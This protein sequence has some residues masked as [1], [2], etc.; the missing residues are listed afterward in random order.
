MYF[1]LFLTPVLLLLQAL[2]MHTLLYCCQWLTS[3]IL[4]QQYHQSQQ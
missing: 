4:Q 2:A 3:H 1:L